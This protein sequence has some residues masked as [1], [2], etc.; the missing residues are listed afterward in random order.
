M[1]QFKLFRIGA[2]L[3]FLA[4]FSG[5]VQAAITYDV[6]YS[7]ANI[8]FTGSITTNG[9]IGQLTSSDITS[10]SFGGSEKDSFTPFKSQFMALGLSGTVTCPVVEG[11]SLTATQTT[12]EIAGTNGSRID[13][14]F[15]PY[16]HLEIYSS[17]GIQSVE[18]KNSSGFFNGSISDSYTYDSGAIN[19]SFVAT[20]V[21]EPQAW[22]MM[23]GSLGMVGVAVRRRKKPKA[24]FRYVKR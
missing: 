22:G 7:G 23:L 21:P 2:G 14:L 4:G 18:Y 9:A 16:T 10:W 3:M 20:A 8:S 24:E 17:A 13:F 11:C 19:S 1:H 12:L 15:G 5:S 6:N